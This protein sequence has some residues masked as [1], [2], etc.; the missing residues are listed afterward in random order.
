MYR[1]RTASGIQHEHLSKKA[2]DKM[3]TELVDSGIQAWVEPED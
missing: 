3:A 1:V 2:A